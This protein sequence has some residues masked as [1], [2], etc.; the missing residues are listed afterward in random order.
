MRAY[1]LCFATMPQSS[2]YF[3]AKPPRSARPLSTRCSRPPF[4]FAISLSSHA[5]GWPQRATQRRV[6]TTPRSTFDLASLCLTSAPSSHPPPRQRPH[7]MPCRSASVSVARSPLPSLLTALFARPKI[8][9]CFVPHASVSL[10]CPSR[11]VNRGARY[12]RRPCG[13]IP[14][15]CP[16]P[17]HW[18]TRRLLLPHRLPPVSRALVMPPGIRR[19]NLRAS[20]TPIA[21]IPCR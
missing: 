8:P 9:A 3:L 7:A 1:Q 21:A 5:K 4:T 6:D 18:R 10:Q 14:P 12:S 13:P 11:V 20:R 17:I 15:A 16:N 2:H 19:C